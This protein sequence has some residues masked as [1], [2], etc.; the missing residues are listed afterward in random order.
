MHMHLP[1][2]ITRIQGEQF[3]SKFILKK[4]RVLSFVIN[5]CLVTNDEIHE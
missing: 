2:Q 4:H 1:F 3:P 5:G